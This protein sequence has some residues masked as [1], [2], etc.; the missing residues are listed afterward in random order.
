MNMKLVFSLG[1]FVT[2]FVLL[3][4]IVCLAKGAGALSEPT[5]WIVVIM[6]SML[7]TAIASKMFFRDRENPRGPQK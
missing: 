2:I 7:L 6:G 1:F 3:W 5:S 4:L